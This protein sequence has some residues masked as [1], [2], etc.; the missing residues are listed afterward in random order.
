MATEAQLR[1]RH[2][3][4]AKIR[5]Y[6]LKLIPDKEMDIIDFLDSFEGNRTEFLKKIIRKNMKK[7]VPSLGSADPIEREERKETE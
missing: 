4:Q 5:T 7:D 2:K 6:H 3:Y 1:A